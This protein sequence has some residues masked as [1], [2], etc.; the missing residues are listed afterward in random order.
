MASDACQLATDS[1][2]LF[3]LFSA[4]VMDAIKNVH[5]KTAEYVYST[6]YRTRE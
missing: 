1:G 3:A 4:K 6:R 5:C 2:I